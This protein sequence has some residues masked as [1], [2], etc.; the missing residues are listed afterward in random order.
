MPMP[1][2]YEMQNPGIAQNQPVSGPSYEQFKR[3][4]MQQAASIEQHKQYAAGLQMKQ[5]QIQL[6]Q[7]DLQVSDRLLKILDPNVAKPARAFLMR[8]LAQNLGVDPNTENFKQLSTMLGGLDPN[9]LTGL[10][11]V[12]SNSLEQAQPGEVQE[13]ARGIMDGSVSMNDIMNQVTQQQ[14][15]LGYQQAGAPMQSTPTGGPTPTAPEDMTTQAAPQQGPGA[16]STMQQQ[17]M[18]QKQA[19]QPFG[20]GP[21]AVRSFEGTR[22]IPPAEQQVDPQLAGALGLDSRQAYRGSDLVRG[23]YRIP[24]DANKQRE[25]AESLTT[26]ASGVQSTLLE[27]TK[28]SKIVKGDPN[29]IGTVGDAVAATESALQQVTNAVKFLRPGVETEFGPNA[30]GWGETSSAAEKAANDLITRFGLTKTAENASIIKSSVLN[31]AYR[32]ALAKDIPGNRLTNG[33]I[34]QH[35]AQLGNS[36]SPAQFTATL[37]DTISSTMREYDDYVRRQVG[38]SGYD[39]MLRQLP[40]EQATQFIN[41]MAQNADMLPSDFARSLRDEAVRIQSGQPAP[42]IT[43]SSPTIQEEQ[44]TLGQLETQEKATKI[45]ERDELMQQ[46]RSSDMRADEASRRQEERLDMAQKREDRMVDQQVETNKLARDKFEF[47]KSKVDENQKLQREQ[48]EFSKEKANR[49]ES[50]QREQFE[51]QKQKYEEQKGEQQR[52]KIANAFMNFGRAIASSR[53]GGGGGGGSL[54]SYSGQD[55]SAF[56]LQPAPQRAFPNIPAP[57]VPSLYTYGR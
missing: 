34:Q 56:R 5:Q 23:G 18:Q 50:F 35:I 2:P 20:A 17:P 13:I 16:G 14:R 41:E 29:A 48:F 44:Q 6:R 28:I 8:E 43:P 3:L 53:S 15:A 24:L 1:S 40:P 47:D 38:A 26:R 46:R 22:T 25:L 21:N 30:R 37:R 55:S 10:K 54:P 39:I 31:L 49:A 32:M 4:R 27:A 33:I 19:P 45:Q 42:T 7:G 12:F 57:Q 36:G 51:W 9:S 52:E 11:Q